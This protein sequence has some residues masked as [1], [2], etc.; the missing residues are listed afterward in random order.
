[1]ISEQP[2]AEWTLWHERKH[3]GSVNTLSERTEIVLTTTTKKTKP[4]TLKNKRR[5]DPVKCS[6]RLSL[7]KSFERILKFYQTPLWLKA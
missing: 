6:F 3:Y 2:V 1:M 5:W 7:S 4:K